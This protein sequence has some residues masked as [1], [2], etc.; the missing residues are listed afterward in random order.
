[1]PTKFAVQYMDVVITML[2]LRWQLTR[3]T[4]FELPL[5]SWM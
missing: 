4:A 2:D 5:K 1:M 3:Y